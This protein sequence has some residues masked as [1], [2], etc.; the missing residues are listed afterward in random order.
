[1]YRAESFFQL[2]S[3][4][5]AGP[6]ILFQLALQLGFLVFLLEKSWVSMRTVILSMGMRVSLKRNSLSRGYAS[7]AGPLYPGSQH[8]ARWIVSVGPVYIVFV[9]VTLPFVSVVAL[10]T[11]F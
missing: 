9:L 6:N 3:G 4:M 10:K 11:L 5:L 8:A 1:M 2:G 7:I